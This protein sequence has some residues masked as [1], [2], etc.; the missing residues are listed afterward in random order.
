MEAQASNSGNGQ[1]LIW[2]GCSISR[3]RT[4]GPGA[5]CCYHTFFQGL[6]VKIDAPPIVKGRTRRDEFVSEC[7]ER[8]CMQSNSDVLNQ[9]VFYHSVIVFFN[10]SVWYYSVILLSQYCDQYI[11]QTTF[12][13]VIITSLYCSISCYIFKCSTILSFFHSIT[14]SFHHSIITPFHYYILIP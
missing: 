8:D 2:D 9:L 12:N 11:I 4:T 10:C 3:V 13:C 6:G 7:L 1:T 5:T 14:H